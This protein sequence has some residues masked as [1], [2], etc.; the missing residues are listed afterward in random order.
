MNLLHRLRFAVLTACL[1][2]IGAAAEPPDG[3]PRTV[4]FT[5][6]DAQ[7]LLEF[8]PMDSRTSIATVFETLQEQWQASR[9][10]WRGGQDEIWGEQFAIRPEN[11][12]FA[13]IWDWWR[14]LQ[15]RKVGTNR[16]A[17]EEAHQ[18]G[19]Q[20]WLTYGLFDNG[21]Q[22]DAGY[23]GFPYAVE[24]K[25]RVEHPEWSPVNRWGTWRQGGPIEFAYPE[26]REA[27]ASYLAKAVVDGNYDGIAFLTYAENF[28]Q[29]YEDEF[30]Y[31]P[32]IVDEYREKFGVDIRTQDFDRDK[33]RR[34]RGSYVTEF[35]RLLKSK[36]SPHGKKIAVTVDGQN[37]EKPTLWLVDGGVRTAGNFTWDLDEWLKRDVVDEIQLGY[38]NDNQSVQRLLDRAAEAKSTVTITVFRSRGDL[39]GKTPRTMFLGREIESGYPSDHWIDYPDENLAPE[40]VASLSS[41]DAYARRRV[42]TLALKDKLKLTSDQWTRALNDSDLFVRRTALRAIAK[43]KIQGLSATVKERLADSE[44]TVRCLAVLALAETGEEGAVD[45][46]L[47]AAFQ[48]NATFQLADRAAADGL[49][50]LAADEQH[51]KSLKLELVRHLSSDRPEVRYL[52]LYYFTLIGAP[53]TPEV[54]AQLLPMAR[55]DEAEPVRELALVNLRSSFGPTEKVSQTFLRVM[56]KDSS[57]AV[58]VRAAAA[59]ASMFA[60]LPA[61]DPQRTAA[62]DRSIKF[63]RQYGDGCQRTDAAWGW[64]LLGNTL[65]EFGPAGEAKLKELM[66]DAGNRQLSDR[67]WKILHLKQGDRFYPV[68]EA[69]DVAAHQLHPWLN[70]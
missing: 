28:S 68:T 41:D 39:P 18:R 62:L 54:E 23:S 21:S 48:P 36:L 59:S 44:N 67:A 4:Y 66:A 46:I 65:L 32:P 40:P 53:A 34:L 60:R 63:F 37:P 7:D 16:I 20:I 64:R 14:D 8:P 30:G 29:R 55:N 13:K 5:V 52:T 11:R 1:A 19:M 57:H 42:V 17:V 22:A 25:L 45:A 9:I 35:L 24:D 38:G 26:A 31:S 49:K 3:N 61:D 6:G 2:Q 70:K 47:T 43:H 56:K 58:Q 51:A 50:K 10:W 69:E 33:W 27:M 15:Y 12:L